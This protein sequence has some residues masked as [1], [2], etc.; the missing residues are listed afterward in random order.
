[1]IW[2]RLTVL[3][4]HEAGMPADIVAILS[5]ALR[6]ER[7]AAITI[8]QGTAQVLSAA[9]ASFSCCRKA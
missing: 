4:Y 5:G 2:E 9:V 6:C 7:R 1:M 8:R 3:F